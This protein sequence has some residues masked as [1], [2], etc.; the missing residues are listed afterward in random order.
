MEKNVRRN[1]FGNIDTRQEQIM[2][3]K[4]E[5]T[6]MPP[7]V[8]TTKS[9]LP[10]KFKA[11]SEDKKL[12]QPQPVYDNTQYNQEITKII[13]SE[14][15]AIKHYNSAKSYIRLTTEK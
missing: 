1:P 10:P 13:D 8:E 14:Y 15:E 4:V 9:N 11:E 2:P 3:P 12:E 5:K 7:K 6:N